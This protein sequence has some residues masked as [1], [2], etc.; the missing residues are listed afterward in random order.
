MSD[1]HGNTPVDYQRFQQVMEGLSDEDRATV[2]YNRRMHPNPQ[3]LEFQI[4]L[5][6][7]RHHFAEVWRRLHP[8]IA[9]RCHYL[10]NEHQLRGRR[11]AIVIR[12]HGYEQN[13]VYTSDLLER[14]IPV[15][16]TPILEFDCRINSIER[17]LNTIALQQFEMRNEIAQQGRIEHQ[18]EPQLM[19]AQVVAVKDL[20]QE[21]IE[22]FLEQL[23]Q[24]CANTITRNGESASKLKSLL[25]LLWLSNDPQA[26]QL[27]KLLHNKFDDVGLMT[28]AEYRHLKQENSAPPDLSI[29]EAFCD[30]FVEFCQ[31]QNPPI[32]CVLSWYSYKGEFECRFAYKNQYVIRHLKMAY[33]K[34]KQQKG[35][36]LEFLASLVEV[37]ASELYHLDC[38]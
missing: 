38:T 26:R 28:P 8:E 14:F 10:S 2:N 22:A 18:P 32:D 20:T 3:Q 4:L 27:A 7:G 13:P 37:T 6:A 35:E 19:Q 9:R 25:S 23:D 30:Y 31:R 29:G 15:G 24:L 21:Q 16:L 34:Q 17:V 12:L 1:L 36:L 5:I 33:L 11:N